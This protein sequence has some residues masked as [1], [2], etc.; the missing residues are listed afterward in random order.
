MAWAR[1]VVI[2]AGICWMH[3]E[4]EANR[5]YFLWQVRGERC[6]RWLQVFGLIPLEEQCFPLLIQGGLWWSR[7]CREK[8]GFGFGHVSKTCLPKW[9]FWVGWRYRWESGV[10][11]RSPG[12]QHRIENQE[13][14]YD[15]QGHGQDEIGYGLTI[16]KRCVDR[17]WGHPE[18]RGG[19][20]STGY[21][22]R[23]Q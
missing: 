9:R 3:W 16:E 14:I 19:G 18:V 23:G 5:I 8:T 6:Q 10:Q 2:E 1:V 12:E 13:H 22:K 7:L 4:G 20:S 11:R 17:P 15:M 21:W